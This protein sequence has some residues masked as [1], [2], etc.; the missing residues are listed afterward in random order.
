VQ[1]YHY[2]GMNKFGKRVS[3]TLPAANEQELEL[4]LKK[5]KIDLLSEKAVELF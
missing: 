2:S 1:N 5:S 4:K 3:G